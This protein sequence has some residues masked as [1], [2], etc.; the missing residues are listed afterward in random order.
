MLM[1]DSTGQNYDPWVVLKMRPSKDPDT[2]EEY[3]RLRRGFSR[4]IWPYIRKI[5][6]ENTMP[7]F[8]NGKG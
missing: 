7:I 1:A 2:R 8:V 5:E 3:T 4:Q 6:E